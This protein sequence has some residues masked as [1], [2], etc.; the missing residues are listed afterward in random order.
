MGCG[1]SSVGHLL[2]DRLGFRF[3]DL[4]QVIVDEEG[5]SINEIF[6]SRGEPSFREAESKALVRVAMTPSQV[7]S[8][9]GGAVIARE[10]RA[11]MREYGVIVNLTASVEAIAE[12]VAGDTGR[13]LLAADASAERIRNMLQTRERFYAD[14]DLRLDTTGKSVET[15]A[16][17]IIDAL[18]G[19]L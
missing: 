15:V 16:D 19:Y 10:N 11:V 18:K 13:P 7:V 5:T 9:G 3:V 17:E 12:R 4:D 2:S 6:A 8:T 14:A 1:K